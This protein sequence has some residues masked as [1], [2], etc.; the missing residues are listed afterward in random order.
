MS[1]LVILSGASGVTAFA[2]MVAANVL[3][4]PKP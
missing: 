1:W 4:R 3:R 2:M